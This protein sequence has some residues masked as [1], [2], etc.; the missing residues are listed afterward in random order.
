[1]WTC[2][3]LRLPTSWSDFIVEA[4]LSGY[5]PDNC[6]THPAN[7]LLWDHQANPLC[8]EPILLDAYKKHLRQSALAAL[9]ARVDATASR[10]PVPSPVHFPLVFNIQLTKGGSH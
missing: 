6:W 7:L 2:D 3:N 4:M 9:Q 8:Q 1:M 5:N 10:L